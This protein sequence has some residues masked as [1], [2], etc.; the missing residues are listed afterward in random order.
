MPTD[1]SRQAIQAQ[2]AE[3]RRLNR[4]GE[5][6]A[7]LALAERAREDAEILGDPAL[8]AGVLDCRVL[9]NFYL[10]H[11]DL[12][13]RDSYDAL[14]L[15]EQTACRIDESRARAM[16]ALLL[17]EL[18]QAEEAMRAACAA[19]SMAEQTGDL[20]ALAWAMQNLGVCYRL[21]REYGEAALQMEAA[22]EHARASGDDYVLGLCL[23]NYAVMHLYR[24]GDLAG[25]SQSAASRADFEKALVLQRA[26]GDIWRKLGYANHVAISLVN[27]ARSLTELG[28]YEAAREAVL[29]MLARMESI[30]DQRG[31]AYG[32]LTLGVLQ[33]AQKDLDAARDSFERASL[34]AE[35]AK[36]HEF[37]MQCQLRLAEVWEAL[38]DG[39]RALAH[40]KRYHAL[41][42]QVASETARRQG[43]AAAIL[44]E[45][46][47]AKAAAETERLRAERLERSN[48]ELSHAAAQLSREALEDALT[49]L[50]NR[51]R[52]DD[53]LRSLLGTDHVFAVAL[54]DIDHFKQ[55]NDRFSH[56][57]GDRVLQRIG[58]I[59][60]DGSRR[61]DL[62]ARFGGEEF[63]VVLNESAPAEAVAACERLRQAIAAEPWGQL[64]PELRVTASIGLALRG[65]A[66]DQNGLLALADERL[67]RAKREG[68][69]RTV[70][71]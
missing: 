21:A 13:L 59:L 39:M 62:A 48:H 33:L 63:A 18:G 61:Q 44:Y 51:R 60:R 20:S 50:G 40:H 34:A 37:L 3:A 25:A 70:G 26:S 67:Y 2:I 38:G 45:T 24:G 4:A 23:G 31:Q 32:L 49:G 10:G 53:E 57:V 17:N 55:V 19:C 47:K 71:S 69:N 15:W 36:A 52:L 29:E 30:H 28:D 56:L 5:P 42:A 64:H 43:R 35:A 27:S 65:E 1:T 16:H 66:G 8:Q 54:V 41:Y 9:G 14:A 7:G 68:R 12:A 58:A 11:L 46:E 22:I 6:A